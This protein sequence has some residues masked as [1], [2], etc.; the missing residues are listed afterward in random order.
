M[1]L[2]GHRRGITG[3]RREGVL[4]LWGKGRGRGRGRRQWE[5]G[6]G[7]LKGVYRTE[8][9]IGNVVMKRRKDGNRKNKALQMQLWGIGR[10]VERSAGKGNVV[11]GQRSGT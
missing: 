9:G 7:A 3:R 10:A 5:C 11:M 8:Q 2:L 4:W 6:Y 1:D